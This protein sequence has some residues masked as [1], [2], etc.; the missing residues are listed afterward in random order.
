MSNGESVKAYVASLRLDAKGVAMAQVAMVL[1]DRLDGENVCRACSDP[2]FHPPSGHHAAAIAKEL[3][4]TLDALEPK[5]SDEPDDDWTAPPAPTVRHAKGRKPRN[6]GTTGGR[7][8]NPA[9]AA[10]DAVATARPRRGT[11]GA[12]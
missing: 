4:A 11:R 3:R 5:V 6:A 7:G 12:T 8:G 9:G 10:V 2:F 1:A